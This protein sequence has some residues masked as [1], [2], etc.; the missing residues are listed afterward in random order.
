MIPVVL[1]PI[2]GE[3]KKACPITQTDDERE[4]TEWVAARGYQPGDDGKGA[5]FKRIL[6]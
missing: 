3:T 5:D 1:P 2:R 4:D 6:W